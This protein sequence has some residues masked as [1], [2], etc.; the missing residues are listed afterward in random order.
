MS[1][2]QLDCN[3]NLQ[4][5]PRKKA[6]HWR[7]EKKLHLIKLVGVVLGRTARANYETPY[8]EGIL[9]LFCTKNELNHTARE[10]NMIRNLIKAYIASL[11]VL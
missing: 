10:L 9:K 8:A 5:R 2:G 1:S 7:R 6:C 3:G 4:Y 11:C